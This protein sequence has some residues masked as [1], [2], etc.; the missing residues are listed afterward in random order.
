MSDEKI[1]QLKRQIE[2]LQQENKLLRRGFFQL[3][4]E[5]A[6]M[7][8]EPLK[9]VF[10]KAEQTVKEYFQD[11]VA[12]PSKGYIKICDQRYILVRASAL[13][14]DFVDTIRSLYNN[15]STTEADLI[16][17]DFL[18][19]IAHTIGVNDAKTFTRKCHLKI[20]YPNF[21]QVQCISRMLVGLLLTLIQ[22]VSHRQMRIFI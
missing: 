13:S 1:A 17:R 4:Q 21:R 9:P 5:H 18:F 11:V 12:D 7:V 8:P 6:V 15:R 10:D 22:E 14:I 2:E 20:R 19:D 3:S 16:G